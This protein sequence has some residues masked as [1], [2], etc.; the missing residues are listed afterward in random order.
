M[1]DIGDAPG[2]VSADVACAGVWWVERNLNVV[3][4]E[5]GEVNGTKQ[6]VRWRFLTLL[7]R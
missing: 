2:S 7:P 6:L 1:E 3:L 5:Q 4:E